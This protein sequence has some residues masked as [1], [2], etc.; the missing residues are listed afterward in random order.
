MNNGWLF[1]VLDP[2]MEFVILQIALNL[3]ASSID[4]F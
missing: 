3:T 4:N 2:F 1:L